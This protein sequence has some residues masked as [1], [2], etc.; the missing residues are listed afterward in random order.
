MDGPTT[1]EAPTTTT[2]EATN[3]NYR[4]M[5]DEQLDKAIVEANTATPDKTIT[6]EVIEAPEASIESDLVPSDAEPLP[7]LESF[8]EPLA[9]YEVDNLRYALYES[10]AGADLAIAVERNNGKLTLE[11]IEEAKSVGVSQRQIDGYISHQ[12]NQA[13]KIFSDAGLS[14]D[15]GRNMMIRMENTFSAD[16]KKIFM[17]ETK[18]DPAKSL[19]T[20]KA[21]FDSE[22]GING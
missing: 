20:L 11:L 10:D 14:F 21:Y 3:T 7:T 9:N 22:D 13:N 1:T 17:D 5:S 2:V 19:Q 18:V 8:G 12:V 16:E 4:E 6:E 15:D